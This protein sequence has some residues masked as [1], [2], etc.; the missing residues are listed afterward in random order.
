MPPAQFADQLG[1]YR[2]AMVD[3]AHSREGMVDTFIGDAFQRKFS[4]A[5]RIHPDQLIQ[6]DQP[7]AIYSYDPQSG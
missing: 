5:L 6:G 3:I 4:R 7:Q 2:E 1:A